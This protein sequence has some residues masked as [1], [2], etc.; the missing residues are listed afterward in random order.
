MKRLR[1]RLSEDEGMTLIELLVSVS[2]GMVVVMA[3]AGLMDASGRAS[4]EVQDRVDAVQRGRVAME[5]ISQRLRSQVCLNVSTP[6]VAMADSNEMRFYTELGPYTA[7]FQP[8]ARRLAYVAG[9]AGQ[10][11]SLIESVW[12][13]VVLGTTPEATA[14]ATFSRAPSR[15]RTL[16]SDIALAQD[17]DD[18]DGDGDRAELVPLFRYFRFIGTAPATPNDQLQPPLDSAEMERVVRIAVTFDARPTRGPASRNKLD[19]RFG[20]DIFVRTADPT[21]PDH[22]PSCL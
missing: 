15:T 1:S 7:T 10:N 16:I 3:A 5:Q 18:L 12:D 17:Q 6:A 11:G 19:T 8:Q 21:D 22:S 4:A 20:T 14:A 13:T 9:G 2:I